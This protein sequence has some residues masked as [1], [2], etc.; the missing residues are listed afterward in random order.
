MPDTMNAFPWISFQ[1]H[2]EQLTYADW[3]LLGDAQSKCEQIKGEPLL[4]ETREQLQ[5]IYLAKGVQA[6]TAIEGNTLSE[7]QVQ[8][9]IA[10]ELR[11]PPSQEYLAQEI[12]NILVAC[13]AMLELS[14]AGT[15]PPLSVAQILDFNRQVLYGL[16]VD[17]LTTPGAIRQHTVR[18]GAYLPPPGDACRDLLQRLVD[19]LAQDWGTPPNSLAF[20]VLKAVVAHLYLAWIHPFGDGNGRTAR[21]VELYLLLAAGV[22]TSAAQLL[23]NH[24][25]KTRTEY[26]RQLDRASRSNDPLPFVQ[27][28]LQGFVDGLR[29]QLLFVQ[30]AQIDVHWRDYIHSLLGDAESVTARR[31]HRLI[32]DLSNAG[33]SVALGSVRHLSPQLAEAYASKS[34]KTLRRDLEEL[35][36]LGLIEVKNARVFVLKEQLLEPQSYAQQP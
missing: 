5:R 7:E 20:G 32:L 34:D 13:N 18:V 11:L 27:Y 9:H 21:L 22:S 28:A 16:A 23:S 3:L 33:A 15:L 26:Y 12:D 31:K 8:Q 19:W 1:L 36:D 6:T 30:R 35:E 10:G 29:E 17:D 14:G 24:Y 25:N 4:P 2:L